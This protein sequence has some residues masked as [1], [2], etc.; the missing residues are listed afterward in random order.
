MNE[1]GQ[2]GELHL[3][4]FHLAAEIL[5][6]S[7][8]HHTADKN[9]DNDVQKHVDHAHAVTAEGDV[10]PHADHRHESGEGVEA[11]MHGVH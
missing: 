11:V 3:P 9:A 5:R 6:R 2:Q 8:H 4:G 10:E 7:P 1:N